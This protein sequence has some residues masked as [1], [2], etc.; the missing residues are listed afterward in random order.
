MKMVLSVVRSKMAMDSGSKKRNRCLMRG[1]SL[2]S[3]RTGLGL[4]KI[5][6]IWLLDQNCPCEFV[7]IEWIAMCMENDMLMH[8]N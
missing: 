8:A 1:L 4:L 6:L 2:D 7:S 3:P 5:V